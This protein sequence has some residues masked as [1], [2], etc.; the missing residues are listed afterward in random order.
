MASGSPRSP[1]RRVSS[2]SHGTGAE[3]PSRLIALLYLGALALAGGALGL[4][5]GLVA[6]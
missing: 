2:S 3:R 4:G 1:C 6:A 5:I